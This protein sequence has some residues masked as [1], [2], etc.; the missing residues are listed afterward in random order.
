MDYDTSKNS[1]SCCGGR[2]VSSCS[3]L[4]E[5][6]I[7]LT[8][9]SP[10]HLLL[11]HC[12]LVVGVAALFRELVLLVPEW[13][14]RSFILFYN[15]MMFYHVPVKEHRQNI[16]REKNC[17]AKIRIRKDKHSKMKVL[18]CFSFQSTIYSQNLKKRKIKQL[19][20]ISS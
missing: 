5:S 6:V 20:P 1:P 18:S 15:Q 19:P 17:N 13:L 3:L 7:V 4:K 8:S 16:T 11:H 9:K 2:A 10:A 12:G 14:L